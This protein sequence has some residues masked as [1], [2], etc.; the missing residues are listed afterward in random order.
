MTKIKDMLGWIVAIVGGIIG[1]LLYY[2]SLKNKEINKLKSKV[3]LVDTQKQ[4]DLLELDIKEAQNAKKRL[5][6]EN[7]E[8]EKIYQSLDDKRN[9]IQKDLTSMTDKEIEDYWNK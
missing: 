1:F 7:Q 3:D 8:F 2:L 5:Q 6:K 9:Q 4:A